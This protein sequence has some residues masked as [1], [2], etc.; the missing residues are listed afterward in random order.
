M[1]TI[2]RNKYVAVVELAGSDMPDYKY[3]VILKKGYRF[4]GY[5]T[6]TK[7]VTSIAHFLS[8]ASTI[9]PCPDDCH[10]KQLP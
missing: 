6:H 4:W 9:E 10:C 7:N 5:E 1:K 2:L 3:T 8:M